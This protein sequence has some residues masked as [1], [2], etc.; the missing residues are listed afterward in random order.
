MESI[1]VHTLRSSEMNEMMMQYTKAYLDLKCS[2]D[3]ES[4][5]LFNNVKLRHGQPRLIIKKY[6]VWLTSLTSPKL[7]TQT[8]LCYNP[9]IICPLV[10]EKKI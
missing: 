2:P 3:I 1:F 6:F 5:D 8:T 4:H 7:H 9:S 10:Q